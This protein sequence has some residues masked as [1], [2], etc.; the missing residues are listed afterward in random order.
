MNLFQKLLLILALITAVILTYAPHISYPLPFHLDEWTHLGKMERMKEQGPAY[1]LNHSPVEIGFDLLLL[2]LSLILGST[3]SL[4]KVY[5]FLPALNIL[6]ISLVLFFCLR[7]KYTAWTGLAALLFL[8]FLPS[9]VNILGIWFFVPIMASAFFDYLALFTLEEAIQENKP[10]KLWLVALYLF[11]IA[12]IHQSSFFVL[13]VVSCI[14]LLM[15]YKKVSENKKILKPFLVLLTLISIA[16]IYAVYVF[17]KG[18]LSQVLLWGPIVPQINYNPFLLYG[19]LPSLFALIGFYTSYKQKTLLTFRIYALLSL[20]MLLQFPFTNI[21]VFSAYQ[22][23]L[24]H[25]MLACIPLSALGLYSSICWI[26][27][28]M[29]KY[30]KHLPTITA[31]GIIT[32]LA[33]MS[34]QQFI[35]APEVALYHTIEPSELPLLLQLK[36]YPP[37]VILTPLDM[38]ITVKPITGHEPALTFSNW[39]KQK[40]LEAF[41][42]A[43]CAIQEEDLYNEYLTSQSEDK[44]RDR[45]PERPTVYVYA[46]SKLNCSFLTPLAEG[47]GFIY[48]IDIKKE[49][50]FRIPR[51]VHLEKNASLALPLFNQLLENFTMLVW[52]KPDAASLNKAVLL[53]SGQGDI[54]HAGWSVLIENNALFVRWQEIN[55]T[56][57][58]KVPNLLAL[59]NWNFIALSKNENITL[60]VNKSSRSLPIPSLVYNP[61]IANE[62]RIGSSWSNTFTGNIAYLEIYNKTLSK[63]EINAYYAKTKR[64]LATSAAEKP[65]A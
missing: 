52:I 13:G 36:A 17:A 60:Q 45:K 64:L 51:I 50:V 4:V 12:L 20:L 41:Y 27:E 49:S 23:Y 16:F 31:L 58:L 34:Y 33:F 10:Q 56:K 21:S 30:T 32:V 65:S 53:V 15:R 25:F 1:L 42:K 54:Y 48:R 40:D 24:Y 46:P 59:K 37:G 39:K 11:S 62:L 57:K 55:G 28:K 8:I 2:V 35:L 3:L 38:G 7:K 19:I 22:R 63:E 5:Q 26:Q 18:S 14:Y 44:L 6:F 47:T 9:N 61:S 29:K 43:P